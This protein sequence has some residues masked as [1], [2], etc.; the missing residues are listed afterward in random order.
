[1]KYSIHH[2]EFVKLI[3][4]FFSI[5]L[6]FYGWY[7]FQNYE[8]IASVSN[9][10]NNSVGSI[11]NLLGTDLRFQNSTLI[12]NGLAIDKKLIVSGLTFP[13]LFSLIPLLYLYVKKYFA[14]FLIICLTTIYFISRAAFITILF[15]SDV[16]KNLHVLLSLLDTM[17]F[18]PFYLIVFYIIKNNSYI[19]SYYL[20]LKKRADA[21][22]Q[23]D[24]NIVI[25]LL[26]LSSLPRIIITFVYPE[27]LDAITVL[28]LKISQT[29]FNLF[30]ISTIIDFKTI[31]IANN[32]VY[33]GHG[34]LG[35]GLLTM[36]L[37]LISATKSRIEN[38]LTF[39]ALLLPLQLF[40]I[41]IR[42]DLFLIYFYNNWNVYFHPMIMH[43]YSNLFI[44]A[45]GFG[46][47]L[48]YYFWYQDVKILGSK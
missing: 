34:C 40:F 33:L 16:N 36:I 21:V 23:F 5:F 8:F 15:Y 18:I 47:F 41:S 2:K 30:G 11:I 43:D 39:V 9:I 22:L 32:G 20:K 10:F 19:E 45:L 46:M 24:I 28:I 7:G 3:I 1:M 31:Y 25:I 35:I 17:E 29:T 27:V 26:I 13:I 48:L 44:Y 4:L 42:I 37:I 6:I 12:L 14:N 38:K